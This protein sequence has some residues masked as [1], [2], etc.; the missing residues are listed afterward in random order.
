M[1]STV[2]SLLAAARLEWAGVVPWS[3]TIP[4]SDA[5]IYIVSRGRDQDAVVPPLN[6]APISDDA[7]AGWIERRPELRL[8]RERPTVA[9]LRYRLNE[10]WLP[11]EGVLYIGMASSLASRVE[12][13]Y[14]TPLGARRPHAGGHFLK[15]LDDVSKFYVH[16]ARSVD[17]AASEGLL[18]GAFCRSV[19]RNTLDS[20]LDPDH[21]FPFANLEWPQGTRKRHG[22]TGGREP[23][24]VG[25]RVSSRPS[26]R[27]KPPT[28]PI[29]NGSF[30][31]QRVTEKDL[32]AGR[33]RIPRATK[34]V[35][36]GEDGELEIHLRGTTVRVRYRSRRGPDRE[37]SGVLVFGSESEA[38]RR[39]VV[40]DEV[41]EVSVSVGSVHLD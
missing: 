11:D 12:A 35:L 6:P 16:F 20:L 14:I 40:V 15:T 5:G 8:D 1:P 17:P 41:L 26:K 30:R 2:E 13:Y 22:I 10:I 34:E 24:R 7:L 31:T 39:L 33:I 29:G 9:Q 27:V 38:L 19:S 32:E 18:L 36:P 21:P 25:S 37:R 28:E 23:K 3:E 4:T